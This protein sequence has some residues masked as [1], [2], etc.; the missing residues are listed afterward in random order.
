M[1]TEFAFH[2]L[3]VVF[4]TIISLAI[5]PVC[6]AVAYF[7]YQRHQWVMMLI[8][9]IFVLVDVIFL[10]P[11]T[12]RWTNY[13]LDK[14]PALLLTPDSFVD[15][16]NNRR[17]PWKDI[18]DI[19]EEI[20]IEI[21]RNGAT[22]RYVTFYRKDTHGYEKLDTSLVIGDRLDIIRVMKAFRDNSLRP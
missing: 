14:K 15:N 19:T 20:D 16:I 5:V 22:T 4:S 17:V 8:P 9:A 7:G 11:K 18:G 12:I 3:K 6:A 10:L 21:G 1:N 13:W 2:P